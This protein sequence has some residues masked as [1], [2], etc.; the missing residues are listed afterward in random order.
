MEQPSRKRSQVWNISIWCHINK[1]QCLLCLQLL[2]YNNNT[3]SMLRHYRAKH[4]NSLLPP[5]K[6]PGSKS[7]MMLLWTS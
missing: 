3:S 6:D 7:L 2:T 1:V 5:I 4:E